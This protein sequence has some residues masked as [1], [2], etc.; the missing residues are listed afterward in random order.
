[1]PCETRTTRMATEKDLRDRV[2]LLLWSRAAQRIY[3]VMDQTVFNG[4]TAF[5]HVNMGIYM[6]AAGHGFGVG[7]RP[8][9]VSAGA[10]AEY[11]PNDNVIDVPSYN[12]GTT[13]FERMT[14]IH[15]CAH[16]W[17]DALGPKIPV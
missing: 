5:N 15:E 9:Q 10:A 6:K 2:T 16:A 13:A 11:D 8:G 4:G 12:Y 3:F 1:M 17:R 14:I 7:F